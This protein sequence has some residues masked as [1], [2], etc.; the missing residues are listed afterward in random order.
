MRTG[1]R[2]GASLALATLSGLLLT[3]AFPPYGLW[4]L[5]FVGFIPLVVTQHR[6]APARLSGVI[7]G[8]GIGVFFWGYFGP[9]F[10][11][12]VPAM[13]WLP[14]VVAVVA[15]LMS[16][17][18][19]AFQQRTRYRWFVLQGAVVWAGIE[20]I[21]GFV[22][23]IG[24]GGFVA[25]ALYA[26][27]WLLQPVGVFSVYGLSLLIMLVNY[28]LALGFIVQIDRRWPLATTGPRAR[29]PLAARW[30]GAVAG[31]VALWVAGS[32]LLLGQASSG[33]MVRV[34]ALQPG[35]GATLAEQL[36]TLG[37]QT[38]AAAA[39]GAR[40][41]VWPEGALSVDPQADAGSD[42]RNVARETGAY[43]VVGY[44]VRTPDG[45]RNEATVISPQGVFLG[46]YGKYHPVVWAGE[47]S[48]S[49]GTFPVYQTPFGGIG[50]IICY[51]LN[52]TDAARQM[53]AGGAG[54]ILAPSN[55]WPGLA[56]RQYTNLTMRAVET[57]AAIV[58]A[59]TRFDSAVVDPTGRIVARMVSTAPLSGALIADVPMGR[60]D[61]LYLRLG[62]WIGWLCMAGIPVF[63]ALDRLSARRARHPRGAGRPKAAAPPAHAPA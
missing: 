33:P 22:P 12:V 29:G 28:S 58:K 14:V 34:A 41:I 4:P 48:V 7:Y 52:F 1:F 35:A 16:G 56:T 62:D 18:D 46:V 40:I 57:R 45:L 42:L 63:T 15:A 10:A 31:A 53:A 17:G 13:A 20:A 54:L 27:P 51:D 47:S 61:T 3:L 36:N 26:Q 23:V 59:D 25:H 37:R 50:T 44:G 32:V 19:R 9:M 39:A 30:I 11:G 2:I 43:L 49:R 24:T 5:I 55:D 21:R 8:L 6:I 60:A 38:R